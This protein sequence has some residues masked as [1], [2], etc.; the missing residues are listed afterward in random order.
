MYR[1]FKIFPV[2][3]SVYKFPY[4]YST[5]L[6]A[7]QEG[8]PL[9]G[10]PLTEGAVMYIMNRVAITRLVVKLGFIGALGLGFE[11]VFLSYFSL[12]ME[13]KVHKANIQTAR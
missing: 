9:T 4:Y 7:R 11:Y 3:T 6:V 2:I 5:I 13:R 1:V 10:L 8:I 12:A